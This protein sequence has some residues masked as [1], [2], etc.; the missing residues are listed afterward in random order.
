MKLTSELKFHAIEV[1]SEVPLKFSEITY[2]LGKVKN[3]KRKQVGSSKTKSKMFVYRI[4]NTIT[5]ESS[6]MQFL[7]ICD[8]QI[9]IL[10]YFTS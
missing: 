8:K 2:H 9:H 4:E 7:I 1:I 3:K 5:K 10:A 6:N